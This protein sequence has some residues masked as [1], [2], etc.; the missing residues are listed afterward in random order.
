MNTKTYIT[1]CYFTGYVIAPVLSIL[2][3]IGAMTI[4]SSNNSTID[5]TTAIALNV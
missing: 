1:L 2:M 4:I 5:N 3:V